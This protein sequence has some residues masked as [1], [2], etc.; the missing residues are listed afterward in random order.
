MPIIIGSETQSLSTSAA[1]TVPADCTYVVALA[2]KQSFAATALTLGGVSMPR[3][4]GRDNTD[5]LYAGIHTLAPPGTGSLTLAVGGGLPHRVTLVYLKDVDLGSPIVASS[6]AGGGFASSF[7]QSCTS[8]VDALVLDVI[9]VQ[10]SGTPTVGA[11]QTAFDTTSY[12][13]GTK[14]F[15]TSYEVAT[16]SSTTMSW[17]FSASNRQAHIVIAIRG[18]AVGGPTPA[19]SFGRYGVRGPVR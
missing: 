14:M 16:G 12:D 3:E 9:S 7:S 1:Y 19:P 4:A 5:G 15:G 10:A 2:A 17:T 11:G 8:V 13:S 18:V 6:T